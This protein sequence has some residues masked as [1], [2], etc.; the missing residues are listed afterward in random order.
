MGLTEIFLNSADF[1]NISDTHMKVKSFIQ[2]TV[3]E[4]DEEGS[5]AAKGIFF[6]NF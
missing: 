4:I 6:F 5:E 2:K 3:V 1:R